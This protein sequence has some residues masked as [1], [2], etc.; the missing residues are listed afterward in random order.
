M[1]C[2][3]IRPR[4]VPRVIRLSLWTS[5]GQI[6]L[7]NCSFST[8]CSKLTKPGQPNGPPW[9]N[10]PL[11]D[12]M[13]RQPSLPPLTHPIEDLEGL[14]DLV[15]RFLV[16][17][18]LGHDVEEGGEGDHPATVLVHLVDHVLTDGGAVLV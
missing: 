5:L 13:A 16:I 14:P 1:H 18:L 12:H 6:F 4:E 17:E 15:L 2:L 8:V 3:E 9:F 7:D 11:V 10:E